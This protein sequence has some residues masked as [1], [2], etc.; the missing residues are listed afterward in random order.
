MNIKVG[1]DDDDENRMIYLI[2]E[3]DSGT[4][5]S[6]MKREGKKNLKGV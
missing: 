5:F 3:N 6:I 2:D 1:D 4:F